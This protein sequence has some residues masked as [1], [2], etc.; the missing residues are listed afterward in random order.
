MEVEVKAEARVRCPNVLLSHVPVLSSSLF[1]S[2]LR[3]IVAQ[4]EIQYS[5]VTVTKAK[6]SKSKFFVTKNL[7]VK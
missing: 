5:T 7:L 6:K 1:L 4:R 2:L 3:I